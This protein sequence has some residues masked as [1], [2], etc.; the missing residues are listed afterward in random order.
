LKEIDI[1]PELL[2]PVLR[3][4]DCDKYICSEASKYVIYPYKSENNKTVLLDQNELREKF[5][6]GYD[7]LLKNKLELSKRKDSRKSISDSKNWFKLTRFGQKNIF[8]SPKIVSPGEVKNHKFCIDNSKSGFSCARVFAITVENSTF[9]LYCILALL[10]STLYKFYLQSKSSL[11]AGG[12]F[13]YSSKNIND[14]PIPDSE[15]L[16]NTKIGVI[17]SQ[18]EKLK[19]DNSAADTTALE[20]EID[21]MVYALYG[22]TEEEVKIVE[23]RD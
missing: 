13:S 3:A 16:K 20:A 12:Y 17:A 5:P 18:I 9:D 15:K 23:G 19:K 21:K 8:D 2:L 6:N 11:K 14:L 4:Q 1:E 7:Y 10:N 22:L